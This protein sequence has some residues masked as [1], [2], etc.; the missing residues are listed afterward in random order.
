MRFSL[1]QLLMFV[2]VVK[3][4]S[5]SAAGRKLGKTQ[6]TISAAIANL[7][8]DLGV[9]LFDRSNRS[10]ALTASGHKLLVQ[11]EAVLER[12]MTFEAHADCL[13]DNVETSLTLAIETPYGPIMP[14]LKAFE[15]AFPFV[16][17]IIRHPPSG[18][19]RR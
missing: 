2:Q 6:S 1:D 18:L 17:L 13:S 3:S 14:V 15:A 16:D 8:T 11:A 10:P 7:E 19:R 5:L 4:G 12:C 9:D